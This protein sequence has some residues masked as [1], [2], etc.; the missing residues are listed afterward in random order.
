MCFA[1]SAH[2]EELSQ[3]RAST[4]TRRLPFRPPQGRGTG[5]GPMTQVRKISPPAQHQLLSTITSLN[6]VNDEPRTHSCQYTC[7]RPW[8]PGVRILLNVTIQ[9]ISHFASPITRILHMPASAPGASSCT[10]AISRT[11]LASCERF[12]PL[13]LVCAACHQSRV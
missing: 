8:H 3:I 11:S 4:E 5:S 12:I 1:S 10:R 2:A 9:I 6:S 7:T 13:I